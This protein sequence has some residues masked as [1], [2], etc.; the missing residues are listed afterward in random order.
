[1]TAVP[2]GTTLNS[3]IST[4]ASSPRPTSSSTSSVDPTSNTTIQGFQ[5]QPSGSNIS[6]G[7]VAGAVIGGLVVGA[8][9]ASLLTFF[10]IRRRA[11][12]QSRGTKEGGYSNAGA[13]RQPKEPK[14][15]E[16]ALAPAPALG[17]VDAHLPSPAADSTIQHAFATLF[18][19]LAMHVENFYQKQAVPVPPEVGP[20]L[21]AFD[22]EG[23]PAPLDALFAQARSGQPLITRVLT[24]VVVEAVGQTGDPSTSILPVEFV[25]VPHAIDG[26]RRRRAAKPGASNFIEEFTYNSSIFVDTVTATNEALSRWRVLSAYLLTGPSTTATAANPGP[27]LPDYAARR[28]NTISRHVVNICQAFE[29]WANPRHGPEARASNLTEIFKAAAE[30]G[31][32]LFSQP[33]GFGFRW[34]RSAADAGGTGSVVVSPALVKMEDERGTKLRTPQVLIPEVVKRM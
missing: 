8:V 33:C 5:R 21:A 27:T 18:E 23:L 11:R 20:R 29:P 34:S 15:T 25:G 1:M 19:Q 30:K 2:K 28:D 12:R 7:A 14:V 3:S 32:L 26:L 9:L 4:M 13:A 10:L 24:R 16:S 17:A 6:G 31:L 22:D